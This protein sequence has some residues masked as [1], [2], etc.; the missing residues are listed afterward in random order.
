MLPFDS[1]RRDLTRLFQAA[2]AAVEPA[3]LV[4]RHLRG[5]GTPF[6]GD[7]AVVG[8]GKGA[9]RMAAGVEA[10][11]GPDRVAG[12]VVVPRGSAT[13]LAAI[14]LAF[15]SHPLP[16]ELSLRAG[17]ELCRVAQQLSP[18]APVL[19]LIGG[20]ASSL[21]VQPRPPLSLQDKLATNRLLLECGAEIAEINTVRKHLSTVKGGGLA[22]RAGPRPILTL[23]LS[24]VIGDDPSVIGSGP[25][26]PDPSTY[27]D[28]LAVLA[29]YGLT[30]RVPSR[31]RHLLD[32][33][34]RGEIEETLKPL[35]PAAGELATHVIGS[36]RLAVD[37]AARAAQKLGYESVV[38]VE[39]LMGDTAASAL[40]WA[41]RLTQ[42]SPV[43][44][45]CRI[46]GGETTVAVRGRGLGGRNQEFALA[47]VR[48]LAG[49]P[50]AVLSAGTDGTDGPTDAAGAFVDGQT[51]ARAAA[52]GL[53]PEAALAQN[54]S[55]PFFARLGDLLRCG[56]TGTNVMDVK[57]ALGVG[58]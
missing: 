8:A 31:V 20:G 16:D 56:P 58:S 12:V 41:K 10:S 5:V 33:G 38:D 22:R 14:R 55:Y 54:D 7:L 27:A 37:A 44:R 19:C 53:S 49:K 11:R 13:A 43:G 40:A 1:A 6:D 9:G 4:E 24:D 25:C 28:A 46:A 29:R 15:A 39:P 18:R 30:E 52:L 3:E 48:A 2:V 45:W 17:A 42:S 36:N 47:M 50:I 34:V 35:D 57:I 26:M 23:A 21:L 32:G 51:A